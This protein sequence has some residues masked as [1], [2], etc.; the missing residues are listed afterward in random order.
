MKDLVYGA[1]D[2]IITTFAVVAG[3]SGASLGTQVAIILG[4]A[5]LLADGLSMAA[6]NFLSIRSDEAVRR[7][8]GLAPLEPFPGRHA[9]ATFGAFV[10]LGSVPL[11]TYLL[12][13]GWQSFKIAA[14]MTLSALF[15]VGAIR[16]LFSDMS[17]FKA[18]LEMTVVGAAAAG[19]SFGVGSWIQSMM[20]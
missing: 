9:F 6:S 4:V 12:P 3:V 17:W 16:S 15:L 13:E 20:V 5:N 10:L 19:I 14:L 1:N 8:K 2:G 11:L 7:H 18:G